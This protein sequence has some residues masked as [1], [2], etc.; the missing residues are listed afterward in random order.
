MKVTSKKNEQMV[1]MI[2]ADIYPLYL[3]KIEK[4]GRNKKELDQ[5]IYWL[6]GFGKEDIQKFITEEA[7]FRDFF[8]QVNLN[9]KALLIKGVIPITC[10][11]LTYFT[12][13]IS[14]FSQCIGIIQHVN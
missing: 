3:D 12:P 9:P 4:K 2:F 10:S 7:T 6:T 11:I 5:V 14:E 8:N 13:F 1:N